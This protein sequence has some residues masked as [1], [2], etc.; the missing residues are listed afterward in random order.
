MSNKLAWIGFFVLAG[1]TAAI[2][3]LYGQVILESLGITYVQLILFVLLGLTIVLMVVWI[4]PLAVVFRL[5]RDHQVQRHFERFAKTIELT[6]AARKTFLQI[7]GGAFLVIGAYAT[8]QTLAVSRDVQLTERFTRAINQL[9]ESAK[10]DVSR[11]AMRLGGIYALERIASDSYRDHWVV[12]EVFTA[13][14]REQSPVPAKPDLR[15]EK[16]EDRARR[17]AAQCGPG[18]V[19]FARED[20]QAIVNVLGRRKWTHLERI[21]ERGEFLR[22]DWSDLRAV[23]FKR[24][25]L[26]H[27][28]IQFACLQDSTFRFSSLLDT[29]LSDTVLD[30]AKLIRSDFTRARFKRS[31][32]R[33][34][35]IRNSCLTGADLKM[36]D[37]RCAAIRCAELSGAD[38]D[39]ADLRS[40]DL[41]G[42]Y[43]ITAEQ[44]KKAN[45][46]D[47]TILPEFGKRLEDGCEGLT[48]MDE[49]TTN[50]ICPSG[51]DYVKECRIE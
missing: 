33:N 35:E 34:V 3:F 1:V 18:S 42:A 21:E 9:G 31:I 47:R 37:L 11:M 24:G 28:R 17:L 45:S 48:R 8:Y 2:L 7:F 39:G 44:F 14:V 15:R 27:A 22:L 23:E 4:L 19:P 20:I 13:Y 25:N 32:M 29:D 12:M 38:L 30:R 50:Q 46:D 51:Q 40:A 43:G 16:P 49:K 6:D 41:S 26:N 36:A 5:Q 10:E